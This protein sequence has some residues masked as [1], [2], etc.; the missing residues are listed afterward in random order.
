MKEKISQEDRGLFALWIGYSIIKDE[1]E[2]AKYFEKI[3]NK[4]LD[5]VIS[6][7]Q[8]QFELANKIFYFLKQN[9][10]I[11]GEEHFEKPSSEDSVKYLEFYDKKIKMLIITE[12][13]SSGESKQP[14]LS[15]NEDSLILN[16]F[17]GY[18]TDFACSKC[19]RSS[20]E[21]IVFKGNQVIVKESTTQLKYNID[22]KKFQKETVQTKPCIIKYDQNELTAKFKVNKE[23]TFVNFFDEEILGT[24]G[25][26]AEFDI[27][28]LAGQYNA[29]LEYAKNDVGYIQTSN[30]SILIYKHE[31]EDSILIFDSCFEY[32]DESDYTTQSEKEKLQAMAKG[33]KNVGSISCDM[34]RVMFSD[35]TISNLKQHENDDHQS[36]VVVHMNPGEYVLSVPMNQSRVYYGKI[37]KI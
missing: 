5:E 15:E 35:T 26:S 34:W 7:I 12:L 31:T 29:L 16:L 25:H 9:Y 2:S 10:E 4:G 8:S 14:V 20:W 3:S 27:N 18:P 17:K 22:S 36:P 30:T 19:G 13:I 6:V 32:L 11:F 1:K 37:T 28:Y 24:R 33:Y 21:S 23:L